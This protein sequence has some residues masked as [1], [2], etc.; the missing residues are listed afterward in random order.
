MFVDAYASSVGS[1]AIALAYDD[2]VSVKAC[3]NDLAYRVLR[4]SGVALKLGVIDTSQRVENMGIY[5][6]ATCNC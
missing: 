5:R 6:V 4:L 1:N 3:C 2:R